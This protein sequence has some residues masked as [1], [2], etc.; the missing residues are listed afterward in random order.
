VA[1]RL[2]L[3]PGAVN[4]RY[5]GWFLLDTGAAVTILNSRH[6]PILERAAG[7]RPLP[8]PPGGGELRAVGVGGASL[9][10]RLAPLRLVLGTIHNDVEDAYV[11][12]HAFER[13]VWIA[14]TLGMQLLHTY[15]IVIDY[16]RRVVYLWPGTWHVPEE[17]RELTGPFFQQPDV[18]HR[19][20]DPELPPALPGVSHGAAGGVR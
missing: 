17:Y 16:E 11:A 19:L 1:G 13:N 10:G 6:L 18:K 20:G 9:L 8:A 12:E 4:R 15:R 2:I 5:L 7:V 3:I 14:G